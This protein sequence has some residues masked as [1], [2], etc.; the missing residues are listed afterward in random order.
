MCTIQIVNLQSPLRA[1]FS[2]ILEHADSRLIHAFIYSLLNKAFSS[3]DYTESNERMIHE[4][5]LKQCGRKRSWPNL[6]LRLRETMKNVSQDTQSLGRNSNQGS[7]E[8]KTGVSANRPL[9]SVCYMHFSLSSSHLVSKSRNYW[10]K[11]NSF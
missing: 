7:P 11:W 9:R 10:H 3:S 2:A 6:R 4:M 5:N 8:Y 1:L